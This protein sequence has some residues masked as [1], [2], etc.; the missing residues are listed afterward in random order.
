VNKLA[1]FGS[2]ELFVDLIFEGKGRMRVSSEMLMYINGSSRARN[3]RSD[4][5]LVIDFYAIV[6]E[7]YDINYS[8]IGFVRCPFAW[9]F[10][11]MTPYS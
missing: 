11:G 5:N 1:G 9:S 7:N 3:Y 8:R 6:N 10:H 2:E 4:A